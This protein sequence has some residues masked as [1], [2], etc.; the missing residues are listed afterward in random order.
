MSSPSWSN[1]EKIMQN[2]G[3]E[4]RPYPYLD[5]ATGTTLDVRVE[6]GRAVL[7]FIPLGKIPP[8]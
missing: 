1:H 4:V 3:L 5:E 2:A 6:H 8:L 7:G